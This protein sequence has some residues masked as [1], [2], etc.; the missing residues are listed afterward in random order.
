MSE[1]LFVGMDVVKE[2]NDVINST[3]SACTNGMT[4]NELAAYKLGV[5]NTASALEQIIESV[6]EGVVVNI[7]GIDMQREFDVEDL[8]DQFLNRKF[9][10]IV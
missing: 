8:V 9:S 3:M 6:D 2:V 4:E 5:L 7:N 10:Y 1:L